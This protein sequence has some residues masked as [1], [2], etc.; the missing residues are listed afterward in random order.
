M[1][2][3]TRLL[4]LAVAC[5]LSSLALS[6]CTSGRPAPDQVGLHYSGGPLSGSSFQGC[7]AGGTR[8]IFGPGDK[9]I[10]YPTGQRTFEFS[11]DADHDAD[12]IR[13]V[14][15]DNIELTVSGVATFNLDTD[16]SKKT[17]N[18]REYPGGAIQYF[19]EQMGIKFSAWMDKDGTT[20][21]GWERMLRTYFGQAL[22]KAMNDAAQGLP[23][24]K[25]YNDPTTKDKWE[26]QVIA[27][28]PAQVRALSGGDFFLNPRVTIQKP[29]I[30][31]DVQ[32]ALAQEQI[33]IAQNNAQTQINAKVTTEL[34][35]VRELVKV[36]GPYGYILYK[37]I[38]D[39]RITVVP[40]PAG[41]NLNLPAGPAPAR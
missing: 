15:Q 24:R 35:S 37:A 9:T 21:D 10:Y 32:A 33:A 26:K 41:T 12:P 8:K 36:L 27:A 23:Y 22:Q 34:V 5:A 4:A 17:I 3:C 38:Q 20:S 19:H 16:C 25:L 29:Q 30:P 14:S 28:F 39:G 7:V 1:K 2:I 40:V 6:G 31:D 13:I 18:G 11:G